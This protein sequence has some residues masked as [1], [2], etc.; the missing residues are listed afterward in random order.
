M[1]KLKFVNFVNCKQFGE[2]VGLPQNFVYAR[3]MLHQDS[4]S[5][6]NFELESEI[7]SETGSASETN[8]DPETDNESISE[9][10]LD[11][12]TSKMDSTSELDD[13]GDDMYKYEYNLIL[14]GTKIPKWF[15]HQNVGSSISFSIG[16]KLPTF[17]FCVAIKMEQK[18]HVP[19]EIGSCICS[20]YIYINGFKRRILSKTLLLDQS[21]FI[22]FHYRRDSSLE[23]IILEDWNDIKILC[24][25]S[26][27]DPKIGKVTIERCGVHISCICPPCNSVADS[28]EDS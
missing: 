26:D 21:S 24:E 20:I 23:D 18:V 4:N 12:A 2:S 17:A 9:F 10:K 22:L 25:C 15:N 1:E 8:F 28:M 11:E 7:S 19:Y 27:Y 6:T 3:G 14:P 13:D 16:W 5:E